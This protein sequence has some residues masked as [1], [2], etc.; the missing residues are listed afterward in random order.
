[1]TSAP[2]PI[3]LALSGGGIRAMAFHLGV[4]NRLAE[5]GLLE[6]VAR[7]STVSG[8]SLLMGL[9]YKSC[10]FSWPSSE[11]F[12]KHAYDQVSG[13]LCSRSMQLGA[14]AQLLRPWNLRYCLSRSNLLALELKQNWGLD[15]PLSRV[16]AWPE[17][18]I[19]GTT[20]ETGKRFRFKGTQIGDWELGYAQAPNFPLGSALAVSA[21]FPIGFG[22]LS[23]RAEQFSW[24]KRIRWDD[25]A[26]TEQEVALAWRRLHLYDGGL[27]DN[28]GVEP[29]FHPGTQ[30]P[31]QAGH[32]IIVSDA[33]APLPLGLKQ[34]PLNPFR[35]KRMMD[36]MS[37]QSRALRV[38]AF[39]NY[40]QANPN[41]GAN[42]LIGTPATGA[43]CPEAAFA[44]RFPT[45]LKRLTKSDFDRLAGHGYAVAMDTERRYGLG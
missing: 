39:A 5:R 37:E 2:A 14:F 29:Y 26:G 3:A 10:D 15:V 32:Y 17:W 45:S 9:I 44:K 23:L 11:Q 6:R 41:A 36:I 28:L 25:P 33:G 12:L 34:G 16:P 7:I 1:L 38:R 27:Y 31:K 19:N 30:R 8:G 21:A 24:H 22:P 13:E 18:S 35:M 20:A 40:L 43:D 42:I 4:L